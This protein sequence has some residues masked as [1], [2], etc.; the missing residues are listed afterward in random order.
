MCGDADGGSG[1]GVGYAA[2]LGVAAVLLGVREEHWR[3]RVLDSAWI[4]AGSNGWSLIRRGARL[5]AT[6]KATRGKRGNDVG[7]EGGELE[8]STSSRGLLGTHR[9]CRWRLRRPEVSWRRKPAAARRGRRGGDGRVVKSSSGRWR[10]LGGD[11][12]IL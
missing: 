1:S 7:V 6:G 11:Q 2:G 5:A 4:E 9:V 10:K 3:R 8:G 12:G